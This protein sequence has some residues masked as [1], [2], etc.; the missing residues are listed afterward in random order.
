MK[1]KIKMVK[2]YPCMSHLRIHAFLR[3]F[4]HIF[5]LSY[6]VSYALLLSRQNEASLLFL[7]VI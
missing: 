2:K 4:V 1:K 6:L 3:E 7:G 5:I